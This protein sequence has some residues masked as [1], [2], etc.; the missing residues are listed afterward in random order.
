MN[1]ND[2]GGGRIWRI[3]TAGVMIVAI[4]AMLAACGSS[5]TDSSASGDTG[6]SSSESGDSKL[7]VATLSFPC[8]YNDFTQSLCAGMSAGAEELPPNV[9]FEEKSGAKVSDI[10]EFNNLIRTTQQINPDGLIV[11]PLGPSAQVPVLKEACSKGIKVII[12]DNPIESLGGDCQVS[13]VAADN[14][15][16]G[17]MAGEWLTQQSPPS[18]EIGIL[19]APPG[20]FVSC[21]ERVEG[22]EETIKPTN[23][24]IAATVTTDEFTPEK[25]RAQVTNMLTAHPNVGVVFTCND[26]AGTGAATAIKSAGADIMLIS[27]DGS[28]DAVERIPEGLSAD[29]AQDPYFAGKESV[30]ALAE[31][32]EGKKVPAELTEPAVLVDESNAEEYLEKKSEEEGS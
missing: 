16:L 31:A 13:Y 22:F 19:T 3:A 27:V 29:V 24:E 12:L 8:G 21:D 9:H 2:R 1:G 15:K 6:G 17:V 32:L 10:S 26:D 28:P 11:F 14:H 7:I 5:S 30:L 20:Q 25:S 4:G 23:L 18:K